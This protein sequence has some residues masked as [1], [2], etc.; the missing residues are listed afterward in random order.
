MVDMTK[1]K[2]NMGGLVDSLK[3][4]I[5]PAGKVP[6]VNPN[7]ALGMKIAQIAT[8]VKQMSDAQQE[9]VKSLSKL[10]ELL[11]AAFQDIE[12]LR[13]QSKTSD[14]VTGEKTEPPVEKKE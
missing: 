6:N 1:L 8:L 4:M 12:A 3:T 7:D 9:H 10:N 2:E 11:N 5:D 14:S 13:N